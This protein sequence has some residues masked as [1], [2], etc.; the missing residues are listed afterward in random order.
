[1]RALTLVVMSM[2]LVCLSVT[3]C[4]KKA[5]TEDTGGSS[6]P[7]EKSGSGY[8][9]PVYPGAEKVEKRD[10]ERT[11]PMFQAEQYNDVEF[12]AY[13][14]DDAADTVADFY[15]E[16]MPENGWV[17]LVFQKWPEGSYTTAWVGGENGALINIAVTN[18]GQTYIGMVIGEGKE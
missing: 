2:A 5:E 9:I 11:S 7:A 17:R 18:D 4:G 3:A 16:R 14:T 12:R 6:A 1:M 13:L 8:D 10:D 15:K